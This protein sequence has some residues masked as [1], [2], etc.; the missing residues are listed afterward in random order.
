MSNQ[1]G[2]IGKDFDPEK[3]GFT[4]TDISSVNPIVR[5]VAN[6]FG[7]TFRYGDVTI[8]LDAKTRASAQSFLNKNYDRAGSGE[9]VSTMLNSFLSQ[10]LERQ[11]V[12]AKKVELSV[13]L[14]KQALSYIGILKPERID[15]VIKELGSEED[16]KI[17]ATHS[18]LVAALKPY[19]SDLISYDYYYKNVANQIRKEVVAHAVHVVKRPP[20]DI[21]RVKL[22]RVIPEGERQQRVEASHREMVQAFGTLRET[23][24]E[25]N[26]IKESLSSLTGSVG[27]WL[28]IAEYKDLTD[29]LGRDISSMGVNDILKLNHELEELVEHAYKQTK[30][31]PSAEVRRL[32]TEYKNAYDVWW[33]ANAGREPEKIERKISNK[34][35]LE[36][37]LAVGSP[38]TAEQVEKLSASGT[39]QAIKRRL[40][41]LVQN[42]NTNR[43]FQELL[44][45]EIP[46]HFD[47]AIDVLHEIQV[48][49]EKIESDDYN[50]GYIG[51]LFK[52]NS[53]G[54]NF[55]GLS[56]DL[57]AIIMRGY[58]NKPPKEIKTELKALS[59]LIDHYISIETL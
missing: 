22:E 44:R 5:F 18:E 54:F 49:I 40:T 9:W 14:F 31:R 59:L 25:D 29:I 21:P 39:R 51:Y 10:Q 28:G 53:T 17:V 57:N 1:V 13:P 55:S 48:E 15:F 43:Q 32:F 37:A 33:H 58:S 23:L 52:G 38:L 24:L 35:A 30:Y 19:E 4:G 16:G 42:I 7:F 2:G 8:L 3:L 45:R 46:D 41:A 26:R 50:A 27:R 20:K 12:T 11:L 36:M 47:H 34:D 6:L 56:G